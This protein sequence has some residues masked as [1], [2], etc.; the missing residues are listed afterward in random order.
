MWTLP[1]ALAGRRIWV[2]GHQGMIGSALVKRLSREDCEILTIPRSELDL[3]NQS[4]TE[5]W[6]TA[7]KPDAVFLAAATVGGIQAN[8]SRPAEFLFDNL[9]IENNIIHGAWKTGVDKLMLLGSNCIY[10]R[11]AEQPIS[12]Y[13]LLTGPLE[14]TNQWYAIAKIAG[15]KL[16]QAY[17]RQYGCDFI[18][19]QPAST[20][21]PGDKFNP[22]SSHVISAMIMKMHQ[23]QS[24]GVDKYKIWGTGKP[25]REYIFVDDL[26]DALVFLMTTYSEEE[27]INIGT[28]EE[29]SILNLAEIIAAE[30][31]FQGVLET[32]YS[33]PDG[34]PRKLLDSSRL[35]E[36]GWKAKT[37]LASGL[38]QTIQWYLERVTN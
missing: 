37:E 18:S 26:A 7:N 21:G 30:V 11:L 6:M 31:G 20:Y 4:A 32:D 12:E 29:I 2:A 38:K 24:A 16:C 3:R 9:S 8:S 28:G 35:N 10:P 22:D 23:A 14:P 1:Y 34:M 36:M 13:S 19:V 33:Q 25:M 15:L 27:P 5:A 17:R